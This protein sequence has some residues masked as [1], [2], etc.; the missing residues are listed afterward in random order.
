MTPHRNQHGRGT[1]RTSHHPT[2]TSSVNSTPFTFRSTPRARS[3]SPPEYLQPAVAPSSQTISPASQRKRSAGDAFQLELTAADQHAKSMRI[4]ERRGYVDLPGA[5][6]QGDRPVTSSASTLNRAASLNRAVNRVG[7]DSRRASTSG[8]AVPSMEYPAPSHVLQYPSQPTDEQYRALMAPQQT[9]A[10]PLNV[11]PEVG[12]RFLDIMRT[13]LTMQHM[14]FYTLAAD[15]HPGQ[16]GHRRKGI[17]HHQ[18]PQTYDPSLY[19]PRFNQAPNPYHPAPTQYQVSPTAAMYPTAPVGPTPMPQQYEPIS[20]LAPI[21][22]QYDYA[23]HQQYGQPAV[24]LPAQFANAGPPGYQYQ[25][26]AQYQQPNFSY[27][28]AQY[29]PQYQTHAQP[30][31]QGHAQ[32]WSVGSDD[33]YL[34]QGQQV[35]SQPLQSRSE[36]SSPLPGQGPYGWN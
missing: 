23:D 5:P 32:R 14:V 33:L 4:P 19:A 12:R 28:Q 27:A 1:P 34:A 26:P 11:P 25:P 24:P 36:W 35:S 8:S 17:L 10:P 22:G 15:A 31:P 30:T 9:A 16:D 6:T 13:S 2:G 21:P 29:H 7:S 3:H 20:H 18:A